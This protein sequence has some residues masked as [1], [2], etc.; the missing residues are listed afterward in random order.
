MQ[1]ARIQEYWQSSPAY[2]TRVSRM[3]SHYTVAD[4]HS[5]SEFVE[6]ARLR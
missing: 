1:R 2:N 3:N 4:E 6:T 5:L